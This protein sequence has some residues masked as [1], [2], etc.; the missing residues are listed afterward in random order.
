MDKNAGIAAGMAEGATWAAPVS[1]PKMT[2]TTAF[3]FP[4][5]RVMRKVNT[6]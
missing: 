1:Y 2:L 6:R 4:Q 5:I 3:D